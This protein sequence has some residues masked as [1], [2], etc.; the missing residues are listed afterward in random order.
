MA[1]DVKVPSVGE[2]ITE[3]RIAKWLKPDGAAVAM[4]EPIVELATDKAPQ[5][6]PAPS[7]GVLAIRVKEGEVVKIGTVVAAI[8]PNGNATVLASGV[9]KPPVESSDSSR[10]PQGADAP[11]SP[12]VSPAAR[13]IAAD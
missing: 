7:A 5:D 3:A 11:R 6:I 8:D 1:I 2:S 13:Q 9:R 10:V 12:K 4:D